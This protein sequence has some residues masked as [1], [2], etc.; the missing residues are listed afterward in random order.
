MSVMVC[1]VWMGV[2]WIVAVVP[3]GVWVTVVIASLCVCGHALQ[4][5][6]SVWGAR[7]GAGHNSVLCAKGFQAL[8]TG[9]Q[10]W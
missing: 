9:P 8:C 6:T 7:L 3:W 2:V 10:A 1:G 4:V 5:A